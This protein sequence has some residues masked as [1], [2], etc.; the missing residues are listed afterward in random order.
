MK[1]LYF[2]TFSIITV[3]FLSTP[4]LKTAFAQ[5][6]QWPWERNEQK[7]VSPSSSKPLPA[8]PSSKPSTAAV[9]LLGRAPICLELEQRLAAAANQEN[10]THLRIP[11]IEK[12]INKVQRN[13][14]I[15]EIRLEPSDCY[16]NFLFSRALRRTQSCISLD[17][18]VRESIRKLEILHK[19]RQQIKEHDDRS[20]Q[21]DIIKKLAFNNCGGV[22]NRE[23][24]RRNPFTNFWQDEEDSDS[25]II[26][27][28][29]A[30]LPFA[31]YRTVCV[32]LCDGFYFPVSF[33]TL[34]TYFM[35]D[36]QK[37]QS[38]CAAPSELYYHQ[39]PGQSVDQMVAHQTQKP[40]TQLDTAFRYRK[41][42]VAGC[43]CKKG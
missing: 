29:F 17:Y 6:W 37:C 7:F 38:R 3:F 16:D 13:L 26:G 31:T 41:E 22:Y 12:E 10:L 40:Y 32:R 43:S 27:N 8:F 9:D 15:S 20:H 28:T 35:R 25:K 11:E 14:K 33:S 1:S 4:L 24:R 42:Y 30:G 2:F 39:N 5:G 19:Q 34:P 23:A 21:D 18:A 36:A